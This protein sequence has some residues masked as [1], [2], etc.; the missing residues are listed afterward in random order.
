MRLCALLNVTPILEASGDLDRQVTGLAYDSRKVEPGFVFFAFAG[1]R[2]DGHDFAP[3]ALR[4]GASAV[5]LERK[6]PLP[7]DA[8]WIR[9]A[10]ARYVMGKWAAELAG[11]PSKEMIVVGVTG[12]NGKTTVTYLL[13]KIFCAAGMAPG[14]IGTISYRYQDR[15]FSAPQ[16]TPESPELQQLL[17]A[18]S[19]SKTR[20]VAMEVSSHALALERVRG[21]AFDGALFTNLTRD[22]LDFHRDMED[23][24]LA[25][26]KFFTDYLLESPKPTR[27]AVI[28][29]GDPRGPLLIDKCRAAGLNVWS[30]GLGEK[31]DIRP[32]EFTADLEGLRGRIAVKRRTFAFASSLIGVANL[33]NILC[34]A[35]A[36]FALGLPEEAVQRGIAELKSVPGRLESIKNA[37]GLCVLVDYAH[38]PDALEKV[39]TATRPLTRG[40]LIAVFGCGGDRDPGK[41]PLMGEIAARLS[42]VV[43]LTSDNPRSEEPLRILAEIESGLKGAA[44]HK[45]RAD[46]RELSGAGEKSYAV[47]P[48]RRAAI[49]LALAVARPG[50]LVLIAGKGHED[51]QILGSQKVHFDDR[52][53]AAEELARLGP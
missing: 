31:W 11:H 53:V 30:Y 5:V 40:R 51:Y 47:E 23:Y 4:K 22:H 28:H 52:E 21:I 9:V 20:A 24:F 18:M 16:T 6:V 29:G 32:V 3:E 37:R 10:N 36:G 39:L 45:R 41:R 42:D 14:V 34:A 1:S 27:F 8:A 49:R 38:T 33:E 43:V 19:R 2:A 26:A 44:I 13:E 7:A 35:G 46:E 50:D 25:K 17:L 12:T 15:S 48:D